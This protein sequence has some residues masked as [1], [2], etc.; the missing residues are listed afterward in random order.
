MS[1]KIGSPKAQNEVERSAGFNRFVFPK[2]E[3]NRVINRTA[4]QNSIC[5]WS[6]VSVPRRPHSPNQKQVQHLPTLLL[7]A[8]DF[9]FF[10]LLVFVHLLKTDN[11]GFPVCGIFC[12][13]LSS[14]IVLFQGTGKFVGVLISG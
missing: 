12:F 2:E 5:F 10:Q 13:L 7:I 8:S 9:S 11:A 3:K 6:H 4:E 1:H 14:A